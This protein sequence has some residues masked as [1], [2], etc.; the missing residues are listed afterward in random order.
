MVPYS[1]SGYGSTKNGEGRYKSTDM[2]MT[3]DMARDR[4]LHEKKFKCA[5]REK[6]RFFL[7]RDMN[8]T[9][10]S[11]DEKWVV[12]NIEESANLSTRRH[13]IFPTSHLIISPDYKLARLWREGCT[14]DSLTHADTSTRKYRII[15]SAKN[16]KSLSCL[17]PLFA[18][19]PIG[20]SL[21]KNPRW[22]SVL[23]WVIGWPQNRLWKWRNKIVSRGYRIHA[24]LSF[25]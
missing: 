7:N 8:K 17:V 25:E 20:Y 22:K 19:A 6:A 3:I 9:I 11:P 16:V 4:Y 1:Y 13:T 23:K 18:F 14:L 12:R 24:F 5:N 2:E 15:L 21:M 10:A